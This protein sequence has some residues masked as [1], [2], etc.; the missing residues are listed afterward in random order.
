[1]TI[2]D[3]LYS[4]IVNE[5][6]ME[7]DSNYSMKK[8]DNLLTIVSGII[9]WDLYKFPEPIIGTVR[10]PE[11]EDEFD[12]PDHRPRVIRIIGH[13]DNEEFFYIDRW[14]DGAWEYENPDLNMVIRIIV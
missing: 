8:D 10:L 2:F 11:L 7:E 6:A 9:K 5:S 1:M 12:D 3:K 13:E 4:S 14:N